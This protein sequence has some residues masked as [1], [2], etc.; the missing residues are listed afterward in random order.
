MLASALLFC[1]LPALAAEDG[2]G[3]CE[4]AMRA[5]DAL[6]LEPE[7]RRVVEDGA[8]GEVWVRRLKKGELAVALYNRGARPL[9]VDV[10]WKEIGLRGSP[11]VRDLLKGVDR[12]KVHGGFAERL[13]PSQCA[14]FRVKP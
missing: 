8:G 14:V 10:I 9:Q 6:A 3:P 13:E 5:L 12:G 2:A 11:R 1:L 7:A 4:R